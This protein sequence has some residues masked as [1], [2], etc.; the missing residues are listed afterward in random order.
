MPTKPKLSSQPF[1]PRGAKLGPLPLPTEEELVAE[2][3]AGAEDAGNLW[4]E[5]MPEYAGLLDAGANDMTRQA[6]A[7]H[8]LAPLVLAL[9]FERA[10]QDTTTVASRLWNGRRFASYRV[11]ASDILEDMRKAGLLRKS[12]AGWYWLITP[13][14]AGLLDAEVIEEDHEPGDESPA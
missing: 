10:P 8:P 6:L 12:T 14:P 11:V 5:T 4:D 2:L 7:C 1:T 9:F 3:M 13:E